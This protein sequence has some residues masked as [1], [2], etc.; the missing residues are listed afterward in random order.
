MRRERQVVLFK[1]QIIR[2][3]CVSVYNTQ[4]Y[5]L[6]MYMYMYMYMYIRIYRNTRYSRMDKDLMVTSSAK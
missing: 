5:T 2:L 3:A 4:L 6:Y 1:Y